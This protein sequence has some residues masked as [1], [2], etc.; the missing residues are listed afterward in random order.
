MSGRPTR[1]AEPRGL[2]RARR[3][4]QARP[5][6]ALP[7]L[8]RRRRQDLPHARGGPRAAASA[9]STWC[10]GFVETHGRAE[11]AA[12]IEGLEVVPR[13]TRRVPRR[14]RRGD[15]PRRG[16]R[17]PA[18][19]SPSSTRSPHTNVPGSRNRK[20]YQDVLELLDAGIN[21]IGA[22]NIQHLESPERP[23]R[24]R[25]RRARCARPS[26]TRFLKQADQVVNLDLAVED[27]L[28]RLRAG[29]DLRRRTRSPGRSSTSS[30]D[31]EPRRRCASSRCARWPRASSAPASPAAA[32]AS[33]PTA[34]AAAG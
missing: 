7:R 19:R 34:P 25:H 3:A 18:R 27:L 13:R 12:L 30:S 16:P 33:A 1:H 29:Q 6:Q 26:P 32:P 24:A 10:S 14:R 20:R 22:F 21:V 23:R 4:R 15:G 8:R 31:A 2:P 11:T 28:E 17:A 9:A 5:A